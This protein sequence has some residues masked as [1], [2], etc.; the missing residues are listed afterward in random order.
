MGL[1]D[2]FR[3][4]QTIQ[5]DFFGTLTFISFKD[6]GKNY[7]EGNGIFKPTGDEI[8]F[9]IRGDA[10]GP[11]QEQ[12]Q[13]YARIQDSYDKIV[14]NIVPLVESEL[15][16]WRTDHKVRNFRKEFKPVSVEISRI[17]VAPARWEMTFEAMQEDE[18]QFTVDFKDFEP[19]K[20]L[21]DG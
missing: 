6:A 19:E 16:E 4:T 7:F 9:L 17:G 14:T 8:E 3:K 18:I 15:K 12:R 2:L 5:D 13:L 10:G 20:V 21:I 1:F 11:T